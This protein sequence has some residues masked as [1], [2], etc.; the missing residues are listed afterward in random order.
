MCACGPST[1]PLVG[2]P[3]LRVDTAW[4]SGPAAAAVDPITG[5]FHLETDS[6]TVTSPAAA[7]SVAT[8]VTRLIGNPASG[9]NLRSNTESER[10]APIDWQSVQPCERFTYSI[11]PVGDIPPNVP[12]WLRRA[13]SSHWAVPLCGSDRRVQV[14]IGVPDAV[15]DARIVNGA[16]VLRQFGGGEEFDL[17]GV[18]SHFSN[19]LPLSPEAAVKALA[20]AANVRTREVPVAINQ[21]DSVGAG[22]LPL[23]ASWRLRVE[24]PRRA[25]APNGYSAI[26]TEFFVRRVPACFSSEIGFFVASTPQPMSRVVTFPK[27]TASLRNDAGADSATVS[28]TL[29]THFVRVLFK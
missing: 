18:P 12:G 1:A 20:L 5:L 14:S 15:R 25:F 13:L 3:V 11:S 19:G 7:E 28:L 9:G 4:V 29:P 22:Q 2:P 6:W 23:C 17:T 21:H 16:L 8:A 24:R 10:G 27:D 26:Y